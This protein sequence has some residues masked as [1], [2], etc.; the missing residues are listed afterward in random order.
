MTQ[1]IKGAAKRQPIYAGISGAIARAIDGAVGMVAPRMVHE[2]RKARVRSSALVAYEAARITR[3]NP[4]EGSQ[5]SSA[6]AEILPDLRRLRDL[7]RTMARDDG[8][9]S[10]VINI[11]DECIVGDGIKVQAACKPAATGMTQTECD[12]WNQACTAEFERWAD[13]EADATQVGTFYD[14]Q[15]LALRCQLVDG[16]AIGHTVVGNGRVAVELIDADRIESP[17]MTDTTKI[18]GGIELGEFGQHVAMHILDAH[19]DEWFSGSVRTQPRRVAVSDGSYSILQHVYKRTRPGQTR[20]VPLLTPAITTSR[21]LHHYLESEL[22]AA[23]AASN[24]ALFIKRSVSSADADIMPVQE[25]EAATGQRFHEYLEPGII[26]YLN[27]GEEPIPFNPNRPGSQFAPFVERLLRVTAASSG[28][29]YEVLCRDLGRMNLS[30]ARAMMR[31]IRRG[32]DQTRARLVR[33]WCRPIYQNVIRAGVAAGR[34]VPPAQW[35]DDP[36]PFLQAQWVSPIYGMVDP[37]TD[38]RGAVASID[39]NL[40]D[41]YTEAQRQGRNAEDVL[42]AR[43]RFYA[44][45]AELE[46]QNNLAPGTL[47]QERPSRSESVQPPTDPTQQAGDQAPPAN[48]PN[49]PTTP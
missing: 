20:G 5:S 1:R 38:V 47:T 32:F 45:A 4:V 43:A 27:E 36:T 7:S 3:T 21:N 9:G 8:H 26:E 16:D 13:E 35:L 10:T 6:D 14:M 41:Q 12:D 2:W 33:Q 42:Q 39:A 44:R 18:R 28:L 24:F 31:E 37:E 29:S 11:H 30:S 17:G 46:R 25:T 22:I 23:R 49:D 15:S 40:S 34:L 48:T 19:P